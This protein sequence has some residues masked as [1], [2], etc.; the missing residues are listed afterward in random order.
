MRNHS[1]LLLLSSALLAAALIAAGCNKVRDPQEP[2]KPGTAGEVTD[3]KATDQ[4]APSGPPPVIACDKP[5]HDFG[6]VSQGEEAVHT[7]T[8]QNKGQGVLKIERARGG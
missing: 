1:R 5:E 2:E 8:I 7:F 3:V 6:K 4:Q